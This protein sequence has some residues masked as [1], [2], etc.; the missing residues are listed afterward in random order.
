M[1]T[2]LL[3]HWLVLLLSGVVFGASFSLFKLAA[4]P[5]HGAISLAFWYAAFSMLLLAPFV[6]WKHR[7]QRWFTRSAFRFCVVWGTLSTTLPALFFFFAAR[8]LPAGI[9]AIAISLVPIATFAGAIALGHDRPTLPRCTG[10]GLGAASALLVAVPGSGLPNA[11]DVIWLLLPLGVVVCYAAEHLFFALKAPPQSPPETLLLSMFV[12]SV[13]TL[14]PLTFAFG[15]LHLPFATPVIADFALLGAAIVTVLDYF[16][17]MFLI[18][19]AG[20]VFTSQAA[21]LV[22][23]AGVGWGVLVLGESH[24]VTF[25]IALVL[26]IIGAILVTPKRP[27]NDHS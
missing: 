4:E 2:P 8:E 12:I 9:M 1:N 22:T 5:G 7:G 23:L 21:Y 27:S 17:F 11:G 13:L 6:L 24:S 26:V 16:F 25:W 3:I 19:R 20:P 10:L 14:F 18:A 15:T